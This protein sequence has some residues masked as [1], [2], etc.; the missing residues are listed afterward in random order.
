MRSINFGC[1]V[2]GVGVEGWRRRSI[3]QEPLDSPIAFRFGL[4]RA[5]PLEVLWSQSG[6]DVVIAS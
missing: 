6:S 5:G 2:Q 4:P 3:T 1:R